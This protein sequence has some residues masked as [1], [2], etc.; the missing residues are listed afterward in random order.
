L[1]TYIIRRVLFLIPTLVGITMLGYCI[2]RVAPGSPVQQSAM[3]EF[4]GI[5]GTA[6]AAQREAQQR[7]IEEF[8][9][10]KHPVVGYLFWAKDIL[11]GDMGRSLIGE[12]EPVADKMWSGL[13]VTIPLNVIAIIISYLVSIPLGIYAAVRHN[14]VFD[15]ASAIVLFFLYSI[16]SLVVCYI[17]LWVF[18]YGQPFDFMPSRGLYGDEWST[19]GFFA[20]VGTYIHH[21]ALPILA[22][23]IGSFTVMSR[24]MRT[25]MLEVIRQDYIRTARAKGLSENVVIL[26]HALRNGVIPIITIMAGLVPGL[27]GGSVI[28][29]T[30]FGLPGIGRIG[31]AAVLERDYTMVMGTFLVSGSLTLV[32]LLIVDIAYVFVDPRISFESR[33]R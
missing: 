8:H 26:K 24:F 5:E 21:A 27:I 17:A 28:L 16:P 3:D 10:D 31:F 19:M 29:E 30:I 2:M 9:L 22:M 7:K 15:R 13:R 25:S 1:S 32:S 33:S 4:G 23:T 20:R 12:R 6:A 11:R 14:D 18:A